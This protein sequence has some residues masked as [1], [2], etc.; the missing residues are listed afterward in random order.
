MEHSLQ[1][2]SGGGE[3]D[4]VVSVEEEGDEQGGPGES[5]GTAG[6][7]Q[8]PAGFV[9]DVYAVLVAQLALEGGGH[10]VHEHVEE[11][12]GHGAALPH[13]SGERERVGGGGAHTYRGGGSS[14]EVLDAGD[15]GGMDT[16]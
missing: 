1:G 7:L 13:A 2:G 11:Q 5:G 12:G 14:V 15:E 4:H 6:E 16:S 10:N 9:G 3:K 8:S